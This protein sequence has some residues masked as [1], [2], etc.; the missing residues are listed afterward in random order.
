MSQIAKLFTNGRSQAVRLPAAYRFDA[1]EVFIRQDPDT[2]DV[3]LSRRPGDWDGFLRAVRE[4]AVPA[5]F[6][7]ADERRQAGQ[8]RDPLEDLGA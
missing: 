7:D 4:A 5:D 8:T 2:G 6:L 1:S 3:I